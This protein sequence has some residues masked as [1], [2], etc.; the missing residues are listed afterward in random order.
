MSC[1][2][3]RLRKLFPRA[4]PSLLTLLVYSVDLMKMYLEVPGN[5]TDNLGERL[6]ANGGGRYCLLVAYLSMIDLTCE[7][8]YDILPELVDK[9]L[10]K[11][12]HTLDRLELSEFG[13]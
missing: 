10:D 5:W 7:R 11:C 8:L 2:Q 3:D 6:V 12:R 13:L 9:I 1:I 4:D